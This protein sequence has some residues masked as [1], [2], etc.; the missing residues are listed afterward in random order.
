MT[1]QQ[2][3]AGAAALA[4][5]L[6][7]LVG[8]RIGR[9]EPARA[10]MTEA[11]FVRRLSAADPDTPRY[12][13]RDSPTPGLSEAVYVSRRPLTAEELAALPKTG[14]PGP[15]WDGVF[16]LAVEADVVPPLPP[17]G[18]YERHGGLV[19][20]GDREAIRAACELVGP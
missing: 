16:W 12:Y 13:Y 10:S 3:T 18:G 6:A 4:L 8:Y 5:A 14:V 7:V 1:Q 2:L 20:Y 17:D 15:E 19:F 9:R 11:R